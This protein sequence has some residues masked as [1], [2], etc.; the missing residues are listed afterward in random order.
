MNGQLPA[1]STAL[2]LW[3]RGGTRGSS[4]DLSRPGRQ[5]M[6]SKKSAAAHPCP[7][8]R[9]GGLTAPGV[10]VIVRRFTYPVT[11]PDIG[12]TCTASAPYRGPRT[13]SLAAVTA[14][15]IP[16]HWMGRRD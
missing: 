10:S 3:G 12:H 9:T 7:L 6:V 16:T 1:Q 5:R 2:V 15:L 13:V 4:G 11:R 8:Q 14:C